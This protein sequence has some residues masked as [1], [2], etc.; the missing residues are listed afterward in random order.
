MSKINWVFQNENGTNLNR[1]IAT[2]VATGEQVTFDLLRGANISIVGTPLDADNLN[3][4][5]TAINDNYDNITNLKTQ[6]QNGTFVVKNATNATTATKATQDGNG[7]VISTTYATKTEAVPVLIYED[8]KI[9]YIN[10]LMNK[11]GWYGDRQFVFEIRRSALPYQDV[12]GY[13][14]VGLPVEWGDDD[15]ISYNHGS[16]AYLPTYGTPEIITIEL[17]SD[18]DED[19]T[20]FDYGFGYYSIKDAKYYSLTLSTATSSNTP[21][22]IS[23]IW[24]VDYPGGDYWT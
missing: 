3:S 10:G 14:K 9:G 19:G 22:F 15:F 21:F 20:F 5:I 16:L 8:K 17:Y 7:K 24:R 23:R 1:Y 11:A 6:L 18:T 2:N 13:I 4:L 12:V